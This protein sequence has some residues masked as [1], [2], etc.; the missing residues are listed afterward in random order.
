MAVETLTRHAPSGLRGSGL[1]T[2]S[3]L[4]LFPEA[5]PGSLGTT[6]LS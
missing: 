1:L 2:G 3:A 4:L 6:F 5:Q